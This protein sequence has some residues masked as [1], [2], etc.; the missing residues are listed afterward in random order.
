MEEFEQEKVKLRQYKK[1]E[2]ARPRPKSEGYQIFEKKGY[3][4]GL[5]SVHY[6][7]CIQ[8][9]P[10]TRPFILVCFYSSVEWPWDDCD[11]P[12]SKMYL[13]N[14]VLVPGKIFF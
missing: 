13:N 7:V 14:C 10:Q 4:V 1:G 2:L 11:T 6:I 3:I 12:Y 5:V 8:G 9:S